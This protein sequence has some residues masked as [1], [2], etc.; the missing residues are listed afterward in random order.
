[1][2]VM[3]EELCKHIE[4]S[5]IFPSVAIMYVSRCEEY[6]SRRFSK[7]IK[8]VIRNVTRFLPKTCKLF[9]A[10][11]GG[12]IGT[13]DA[14]SCEMELCEG[15]SSMFLAR[16]SAISVHD[17]FFSLKD[18]RS[19]SRNIEDCTGLFPCSQISDV[20]LVLLNACSDADVVEDAVKII[21]KVSIVFISNFLL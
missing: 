2:S 14:L 3:C 16:S 9:P 11:G 7:H 5:I 19:A 10:L 6:F 21:V 20:K 8:K 1:M 18:V 13:N 15:I 12:I 17:F 4:A